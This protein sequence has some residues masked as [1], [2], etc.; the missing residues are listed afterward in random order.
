[1]LL[2]EYSDLAS[3]QGSIIMRQLSPYLHPSSPKM[4][5]VLG[6][7]HFRDGSQAINLGHGMGIHVTLLGGEKVKQ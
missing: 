1:M 2:V 5:V 4:I 7:L 6:I 3:N